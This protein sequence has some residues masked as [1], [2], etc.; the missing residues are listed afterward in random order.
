MMAYP[1]LLWLIRFGGYLLGITKRNKRTI[2]AFSQNL[3]QV[4]L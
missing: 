3:N 2:T 1:T 4:C